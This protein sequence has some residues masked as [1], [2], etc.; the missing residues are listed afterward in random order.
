M[1]KI[2]QQVFND[3]YEKAADAVDGAKEH[4]PILD[5]LHKGLREC[6]EALEKLG[7]VIKDSDPRMK[8]Y[9]V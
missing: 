6:R 9:D 3:C 5:R 8:N 7:L 1:E 2:S 4:W